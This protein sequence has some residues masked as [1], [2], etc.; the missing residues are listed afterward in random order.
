MIK[1]K[2][3][4][5]NNILYKNKKSTMTMRSAKMKVVNEKNSR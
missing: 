4:K 3:L 1:D 2:K 5:K